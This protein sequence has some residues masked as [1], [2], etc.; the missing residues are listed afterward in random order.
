MRNVVVAI[1]ALLVAIAYRSVIRTV[2]AVVMLLGATQS[3]AAGPFLPAATPS[4]DVFL[5]SWYQCGVTLATLA[6]R[7]L[8][9]IRVLPL[10]FWRYSVSRDPQFLELLL[11][12]SYVESRYIPT[13]Q[14]HAGA[15]GI[16]Q[17]TLPAATT[18]YPLCP[19]RLRPIRVPTDLHHPPTSIAYGSCYLRYL[20]NYTGGDTDRA[21]IA[22]N[23]G[24]RQL[25]RYDAGQSIATETANYVL[26]VRR[27]LTQCRA[28]Q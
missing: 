23:G 12:L 11:A 25:A 27:A 4:S 16:T 18:A 5:T 14:S 22:Y 15:Y 21:L 9:E 26:R 8:P 2:A 24:S 3:N 17:V 1:I 20:L 6:R 7:P 13:A 10:Q 28:V 19:T